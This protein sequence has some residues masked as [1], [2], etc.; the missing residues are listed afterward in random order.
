MFGEKGL[1]GTFD[2]TVDKANRLIL[3][4]K[5]LPEESDQ[6]VLV[7][8]EKG[9]AI[10]SLEEFDKYLDELLNAMKKKGSS[11]SKIEKEYYKILKNVIKTTSPDK[12]KRVC[13]GSALNNEKSFTLL[14]CRNKLMIL[15]KEQYKKIDTWA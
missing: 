8:E 14:G 13:L 6:L 2:V 10:Y 12:T 5:T 11:K 9:V 15:T 4:A 7:K 1:Y 3:P